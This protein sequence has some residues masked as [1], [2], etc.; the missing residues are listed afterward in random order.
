MSTTQHTPGPWHCSSQFH[1]VRKASD[2]TDD[3][4]KDFN[5]CE[6]NGCLAEDAANARLIAAA[7][8]LL[9]E[10]CQAVKVIEALHGEVAWDIYYNNAPEMKRIRAAIAKASDGLADSEDGPTD[11]QQELSRAGHEASEAR[12]RE[13]MQ[14]SGRGHL[15]P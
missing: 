1:Y 12:Y 11:A 13:Q 5:I 9:F 3:G 10:L 4:P 7:P 15:L 8:D 14:Q 2:N 6:M